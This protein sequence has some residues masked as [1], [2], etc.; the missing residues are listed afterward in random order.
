MK[1]PGGAHTIEP[2]HVDV[3]QN[4]FGSESLRELDCRHPIGR[5]SQDADIV[6]RLQLSS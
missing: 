6:L 3:H 5:L 2:R 1:I 4:D